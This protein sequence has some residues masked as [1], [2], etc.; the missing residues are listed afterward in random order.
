MGIKEVL[1]WI[2]EKVGEYVYE[3]FKN[4]VKK[5]VSRLG[6]QQRATTLNAGFTIDHIHVSTS[7]TTKD[8]RNVDKFFDNFHKVYETAIKQIKSK[9]IPKEIKEIR[10]L[11]NRKTKEWEIREGFSPQPWQRFRFNSKTEKWERIH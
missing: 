5:P 1:V 8:P 2:A 7:C 10:F 9:T 4:N 11:M 3:K 6:E